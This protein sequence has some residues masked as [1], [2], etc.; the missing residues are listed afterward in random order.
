MDNN[1]SLNLITLPKELAVLLEF[2]KEHKDESNPISR[3]EL[4]KDMGWDLFIEL[5]M[6][7]RVFPLLYSKLKKLNASFIPKHV[8]QTLKY[9]YKRNTLQMLH[10][11]A[12]IEKINKLFSDRGMRLLFL[13]GPILAQ[14]LY[15]DVSLRT[16]S[17]LDFII[18][19]E[20]L[21]KSEEILMEQ[22]YKKD[23]YIDTVLSDWK[24]R[25][26]HMTYYHSQKGI[27]VE[28][29]WRL[30]P[31]P[32]KEQSFNELWERKNC[33]S[34]TSSPVYFLGNED[35]FLFLVS[36]G[37]RH[38]WSRLRWIIDIHQ[39]LQHNLDWKKLYQLLEKYRSLHVGG[40][41]II[42]SSQLFDTKV[43][44]ELQSLLVKNH[45]RKLAQ[46]AVFYLE[47]MVN[48]HSEPVPKEVSNYHKR[49][50]F[51]LMSNHQ[52]LLFIL[53]FLYP[54]PEDAKTLPLP[55][56]LH[57]LYVPLRPILWIWRKTRKHALY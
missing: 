15:G 46:E 3:E 1:F 33:S 54:Y 14:S 17:D 29:H 43:P 23:D 11:S 28:I 5:S 6:H 42:L 26:H 51:S 36:H 9:H 13:K 22:G 37:A 19:M 24:W 4:F 21:Q 45:A 25:H 8:I 52:K 41:A 50:L 31:G 10:M 56:L 7:H 38:G 53:S 39:I 16:S 2:M 20:Q 47:R 34:L 30:H 40:Q 32:G 27:K 44:K 55:K 35:L 18:P 57:F 48:L 49:H 12:E